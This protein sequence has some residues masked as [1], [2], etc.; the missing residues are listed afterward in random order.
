MKQLTYELIQEYGLIG[1][2]V[3]QSEDSP[4]LNKNIPLTLKMEE[5][6]ALVPLVT[7]ELQSVTTQK[8]SFFTAIAM[9]T[10][11]LVPSWS[12][13]RQFTLQVG[14]YLAYY[15]S[16]GWELN[17]KHLLEGKLTRETSPNATLFPKNHT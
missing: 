2:D 10:S 11:N 1:C 16:S 4:I 14:H 15:T 9:T 3:I 5:S 7:S 6:C 12:G 8:N 17:T 13:L